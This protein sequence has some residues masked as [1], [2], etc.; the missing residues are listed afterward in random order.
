MS[1]VT[2]DDLFPSQPPP[3]PLIYPHNR[4]CALQA[5]L[6]TQWA[7]WHVTKPWSFACAHMLLSDCAGPVY[8]GVGQTNSIV[9]FSTMVQQNEEKRRQTEARCR[10]C[11]IRVEWDSLKRA[12]LSEC[13]RFLFFLPPPVTS[14]AFLIFSRSLWTTW[15]RPDNCCSNSPNPSCLGTTQQNPKQLWVLREESWMLTLCCDNPLE[16]PPWSGTTIPGVIKTG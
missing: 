2:N 1:T 13:M 5:H 3:T 8:A 4:F 9:D 16:Q 12:V 14:H 6:Q 11:K 10:S 7:A 15:V